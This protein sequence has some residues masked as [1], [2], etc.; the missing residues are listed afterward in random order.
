VIA[1]WPR[2]GDGPR[3]LGRTRSVTV[4][5]YVLVPVCLGVAFLPLLKPSGPGN[6][7]PVDVFFAVAIGATI[8][9]AGLAGQDLR[10]PYALAVGLLMLGGAIGS[11]AGP[12]PE[13]GLLSLVQDFVL[14]IWCG[15]LV[16]TARSPVALQW[17]LRAWVWSS[18]AW[19][20][21]LVLAVA[22]GNYALA[23]ITDRTGVR[24]A[25]T[26]GDPNYAA[27]YFFVSLMILMSARIPRHLGLRIAGAVLLIAG[28]ALTGS[29]GGILATAIGLGVVFLFYV[30]R[31][32][33][34]MALVATGGV[35][36]AGAVIALLM[37]QA[38]PLE[39]WAR[40]SGVPL[41]RDSVGRSSQSAQERAWLIQEMTALYQQGAPWGLG[42]GSTKPILQTELAPYAYQT[43]DDY[44]ESIV[45]RGFIGAFGLLVLIGAVG[46][47][48]W[49]VVTRPLAPEFAAL[50][51]R[52]SPLVGAVVGLAVSASYYQIL[53]FRHVWT[54][55]AIIAGLFLWARRRA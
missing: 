34:P 22:S 19:A 23:G 28:L 45:E 52:K 7:S 15:V 14:L 38:L 13:L 32:W 54:L 50:F 43:H 2:T 20:L 17:I 37:L 47:R 27:N 1:T 44:L 51:P 3:A 8:L 49:A 26:F 39:V 11:L 25:L 21:V 35:A 9:W 4:P 12:F 29:N 41:L 10:L 55:L 46:V 31:R 6:S 24:A 36:A 5:A 40:D 30:Y 48:T 16:N 42:P 18:I 33:G 53:H